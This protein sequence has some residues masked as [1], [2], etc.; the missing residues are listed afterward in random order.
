MNFAF[1]DEQ[2]EL[3]RTVRR[4]LDERSPESEVRR[5]METEEGL[6][7]DVWAQLSS[8]LSLPGLGIPE[9]YD[10]AGFGYLELAVVFEEMGRALFC[11]PYFATVA[12]AANALLASDDDEA[13]K[14]LLP[15]IARGETLATLAVTEHDGAWREASI[16][17]SATS[18]DDGWR[19]TG[20][21]DYVVDGHIADL[22]L[23]AARSS[24]GLSLFAVE[25]ASPGLERELLH[26]LDETRKL[27]RVRLSD[28]PARLI[29]R[30]GAAWAV[31]DRVLDLAA[32]ALSLEAVGGAQRCLDMAVDY[33]KVRVQFG[34]PIGSFQAVKHRC[35]DMLVEVEGAKSAAY[36]AAWC[37][38]ELND[39]LSVSASLA[40]AYCTEVFA[41][42]AADNI[43]VHG[44]IGFT[45][46][47]PA[48]L[49]L[50]R[51]KSSELLLGD[52]ATHRDR[53]GIR[54]G[55]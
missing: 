15:G 19:L 47:H 18:G 22:L 27:A 28:T 17:T 25:S 7:R 31:L 43:Q 48:H 12:L 3:R 55:I 13:K 30:D 11:G 14:D 26:T 41:N 39:E 8:Q 38:A 37:A 36:F 10:G 32:V 1:S 45:W 54:L 24:A 50:K 16:L 4:F 53:L 5:L 40:K 52:P 33:A 2:E 51:A 23:V 6:D 44:G 49:Y 29:G 46:D 9:E 20:T 42:A 34:R 35:A 21:K